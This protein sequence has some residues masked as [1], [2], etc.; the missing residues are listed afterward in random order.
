MITWLKKLFKK[1]TSKSGIVIKHNVF[2]LMWFDRGLRVHQLRVHQLCE[3]YDT[4]EWIPDEWEINSSEACK[5]RI[6]MIRDINK[7]SYIKLNSRDFLFRDCSPAIGEFTLRQINRIRSE[8]PNRA[9]SPYRCV[10]DGF[11]IPQPRG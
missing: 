11:T 5:M 3:R 9:T 10:R 7:K 8:R 4:F 2:C 6:N 1:K